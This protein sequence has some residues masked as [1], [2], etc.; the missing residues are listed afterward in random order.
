[1]DS[2][3]SKFTPSKLLTETGGM[4]LKAKSRMQIDRPSLSRLGL[5]VK[6]R[7]EEG[8]AFVADALVGAVIDIGEKRVP[9]LP[10]LSVV[11]GVTVVLGS[12]VAL[13]CQTIQD[14]LE[15]GDRTNRA[16]ENRAQRM[17]ITSQAEGAD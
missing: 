13:V 15:G 11:D 1:M 3:R 14:R 4:N 9:A 16:E 2:R 12:D 17:N 5:R 8:L 6:L 10:E 7:A